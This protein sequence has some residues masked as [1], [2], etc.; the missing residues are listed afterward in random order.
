[1]YSLCKLEKLKLIFY[2]ITGNQETKMEQKKWHGP[3]EKMWE[4]Y[5][6]TKPCNNILNSQ[7][8]SVENCNYAHSLEQ[9]IAAI[10]RRK[11]KSDDMIV[12]QLK[13][14]EY[15]TK[16]EPKRMRTE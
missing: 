7:T 15:S 10:T 12:H 9:Y 11:F 13:T 2:V 3:K 14:L 4:W 5:K 1:M 6:W 16:P 8:C